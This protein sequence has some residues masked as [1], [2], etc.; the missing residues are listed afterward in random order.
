MQHVTSYILH[1]KE[2]KFSN[3]ILLLYNVA[4]SRYI[5]GGIYY[6]IAR[7]ERNSTKN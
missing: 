4:A 2:H 7:L 5:V 3:E 6:R 1:N